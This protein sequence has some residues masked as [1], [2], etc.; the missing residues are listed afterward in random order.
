M[1]ISSYEST[2]IE[3]YE[4]E[5]RVILQNICSEYFKQQEK[6]LVDKYFSKPIESDISQ[7]KQ[8]FEPKNENYEICLSLANSKQASC[9][10]NVDGDKKNLSTKRRKT[11]PFRVKLINNINTLNSSK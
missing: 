3:S 8:A 7:N 11:N 2:E 1:D 6:C 4:Y 5:Y 9:I 10:V